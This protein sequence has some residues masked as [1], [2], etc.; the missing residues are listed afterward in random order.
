MKKLLIEENIWEEEFYEN[1]ITELI[2][3]KI[4]YERIT[5]IPFDDN[6]KKLKKY[7]SDYLFYGSLDLGRDLRQYSSCIIFNTP[8]FYRCTYYYPQ[9][10]KYLLNKNYTFT[11]FS[12]FQI[13]KEYYINKFGKD[14][15]AFIKPD[16]GEKIFTGM[17]VILKLFDKD[18]EFINRYSDV[19]D[20][21]QIVVSEPQNIKKEYRFLVN[22]GTV[23]TGSQYKEKSFHKEREILPDEETFKFAQ[24]VVNDI[25]YE[26]DPLWVVDIAET[27][28]E[29][30]VLEIGCFSS[31]GLYSCNVN[32]LVE[33][34]K[35]FLAA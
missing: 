6:Y 35:K 13:H 7:G 12:D 31:C 29:L 14:G 20:D 32:I 1:F 2:K 21:T 26:A 18:I 17:V 30:K 25:K 8:L 24:K 10:E 3:E 22:Q 4:P 5:Y 33:A 9:F 19:P 23:I 16:S 11:T 27:E 28:N 15:A 34:L